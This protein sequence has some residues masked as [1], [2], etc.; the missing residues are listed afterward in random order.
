M[1]TGLAADTVRAANGDVKQTLS[2]RV[3]EGYISRL[4]GG[5]VYSV[6]N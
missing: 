3:V 4:C 5:V 1:V 6:N 2:R